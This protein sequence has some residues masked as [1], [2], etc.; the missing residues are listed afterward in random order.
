MPILAL[1]NPWLKATFKTLGAELSSLVSI[2]NNTEHI[3]Q[4]DPSIWNRHAPILFPIVGQVENNSYSFE[5]KD[6]KMSQ[7]GFARD[8]QFKVES[9]TSDSIVFSLDSDEESSK[10]YPFQFSL[11]VM[12]TLITDK[13]EI[14]Y[15]VVNKD[16]KKIY[17][18]IGAHPGLVCPFQENE[19]FEDYILE[20]EKP[21][22][23][24]R[25]F[26]AGGLLNGNIQEKYLENSQTIPL[27]YD[28]FK[29]DAIILEGLVSEYVDLKSTKSGKYLRFYFKDFP[30]LAFWTKPGM[31]ADFIC[32]EPWFGVADIKGRKE[33]FSQKPF[34]QSLNIDDK[35]NCQY[36][37]EIKS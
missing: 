9:Q 35:F 1:E 12:Y 36:A 3:W 7:H 4:A 26:F 18:S 22:T 23:A 6:F 2:T 17:F 25:H 16:S 15:K 24:T 8:R 21:E 20:F 30:L 37:I 14:S 33:N 31:N 19:S 11:F 5:G 34:I 13:L 10:I 32:I 27:S 29:D 28:L